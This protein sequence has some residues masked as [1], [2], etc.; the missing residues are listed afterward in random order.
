MF[1]KAQKNG[2]TSLSAG[3]QKVYNGSKQ[4]QMKKAEE[5]EQKLEKISIK[6]AGPVVKPF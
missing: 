3:L 5:T 6:L 1:M 2:L 4:A